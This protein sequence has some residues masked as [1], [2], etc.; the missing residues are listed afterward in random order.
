MSHSS[1]SDNASLS[2]FP[3][4]D[5]MLEDDQDWPPFLE[6][7]PSQDE[8]ESIMNHFGITE[9][10]F[11]R[12]P[13]QDPL[14]SN[15]ELDYLFSSQDSSFS[16]TENF[17]IS[18]TFSTSPTP[19]TSPTFNSSPA[20]SIS[21]RSSTSPTARGS[22]A[23]TERQYVFIPFDY[24]KQEPTEEV[25]LRQWRNVNIVVES[26]GIDIE[27]TGKTTKFKW[28]RR[29]GYWSDTSGKKATVDVPDMF[30]KHR[31]S[32]YLSVRPCGE[33]FPVTVWF[34]GTKELESFTGDDEMNQRS[35]KI[36]MK[37]VKEYFG[38]PDNSIHLP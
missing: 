5:M 38:H 18:P 21:S 32:A 28:R 7:M 24:T 8:L 2:S 33:G 29:S 9:T 22:P 30:T 14:F 25:E 15:E 4:N 1:S 6:S 36:S 35:I 26:V 17:C 11:L 20:P 13:M 16:S 34:H 31:R 3:V 12:A 23:D 10:D 19:G 27:G 37:L